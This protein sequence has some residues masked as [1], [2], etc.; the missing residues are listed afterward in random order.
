[1]PLVDRDQPAGLR[2]V[3]PT[4]QEMTGHRALKHENRLPQ[5]TSLL[6]L[7]VVIKQI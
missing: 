5:C 6:P 7:D 4:D 2:S 3:G 1:M